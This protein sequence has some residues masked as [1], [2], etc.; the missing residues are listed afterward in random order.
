MRRIS[1]PAS[2]RQASPM[3]NLSRRAMLVAEMNSP[4]TLR[5]GNSAFSTIATARPCLASANAA[6]EP[7]G[8]A[9]MMTAS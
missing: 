5:R 4:H 6:Q 8:P 3:S 1:G 7:A 9:P 2:F